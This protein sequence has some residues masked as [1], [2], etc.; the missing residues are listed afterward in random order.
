MWHQPICVTMTRRRSNP[1]AC[2]GFHRT[3]RISPSC[4]RSGCFE[5]HVPQVCFWT[6]SHVERLCHILGV[7]AESTRPLAPRLVPTENRAGSTGNGKTQPRRVGLVEG[8]ERHLYNWLL[9]SFDRT[10][11]GCAYSE[12]RESRPLCSGARV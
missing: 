10:P 6:H 12:V 4:S 7:R 2:Y 1:G 9:P 3:P 8:R 5:L 11:A